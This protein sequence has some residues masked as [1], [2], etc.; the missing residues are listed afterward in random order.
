MKELYNRSK[1]HWGNG[2]WKFI[3][4]ITVV[5]SN[6]SEF[7]LETNKNVVNVL[8]NLINVFPCSLCINTYKEHLLKLREL[9]LS[10]AMVLFYWS[11]DLHNFVNKKLD[12]PTWNYID[13]RRH[14]CNY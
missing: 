8:H 7:I 5:D 10:E 11:V 4:S 13:A 14:W 3:H 12:K 1:Y 2:L 6:N 9:D